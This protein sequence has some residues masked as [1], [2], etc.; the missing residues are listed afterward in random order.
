VCLLHQLLRLD[1]H[2]TSVSVI[3]EYG[4]IISG[5][6]GALPRL[7]PERKGKRKRKFPGPQGILGTIAEPKRNRRATATLSP[8]LALYLA[9]DGELYIKLQECLAQD[10]APILPLPSLSAQQRPG[11]KKPRHGIPTRE[12]PTVVRR[13]IDNQEPLRKV[14]E[15]YGVSH[16]TVRRTV[17]AAV[18]QQGIISK[19]ARHF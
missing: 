12:W 11:P 9:P 15:D 7:L 18:C 8:V 5:G 19:K 10:Q 14:A 2:K 4:E 3:L 1:W 6:I 17:R 16:E 13:V